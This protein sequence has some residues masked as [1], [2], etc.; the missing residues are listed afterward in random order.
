MWR[1]YYEKCDAIKGIVQKDCKG[2]KHFCT[3]GYAELYSGK[4]I[5]KDIIV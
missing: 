3:T 2:Q 5:G 4:T 1:F